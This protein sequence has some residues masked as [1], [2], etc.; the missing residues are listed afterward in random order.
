M[1]VDEMLAAGWTRR[2]LIWVPPAVFPEPP[3]EELE[4]YRPVLPVVEPQPCGTKAAN[5]RHYRA[6]VPCLRCERL[7]HAA[8]TSRMEKIA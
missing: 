6:G 4:D 3:D 8:G 2:G 5:K 1:T 7:A